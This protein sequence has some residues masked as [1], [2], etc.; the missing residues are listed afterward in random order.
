MTENTRFRITGDHL[1]EQD[2]ESEIILVDLHTKT[3]FSLTE[4]AIEIWRLVS[5]GYA[6]AE[7]LEHLQTTFNGERAPLEQAI[8]S[9]VH[10]LKNGGA[11]VLAPEL[12]APVELLPYDTSANK[13]N[14][15][16]PVI[17]R[18]DN[19]EAPHEVRERKRQEELRQKSKRGFSFVTT[20][21]ITVS[22]PGR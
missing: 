3:Y 22:G 7:I 4:S 9:V 21:K 2:L 1:V 11:I 8:E 17:D 20:L 18:F 6:T 10:E 15:T 12:G 13:R 14:F 16:P 5:K 19:L